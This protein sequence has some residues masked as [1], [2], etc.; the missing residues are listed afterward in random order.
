[1]PQSGGSMIRINPQW[2]Q[3][4]C[5]LRR[6]VPVVVVRVQMLRSLMV[7]AD[8]YAPLDKRTEEGVRDVLG[9][10][11]SHFAGFGELRQFATQHS[12]ELYNA[13]ANGRVY[14]HQQHGM[15]F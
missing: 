5:R 1:M 8:D 10:L 13:Q 11:R 15:F 9:D 7:L 4:M 6:G 12:F 2:I 3:I 14:E